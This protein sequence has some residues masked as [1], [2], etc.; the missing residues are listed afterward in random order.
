MIL[1]VAVQTEVNKTLIH[2]IAGV[3]ATWEATFMPTIDDLRKAGNKAKESKAVTLY[4]AVDP[5][6]EAEV[7]FGL[8]EKVSGPAG[9][10][11]SVT[12]QV[13]LTFR[14]AQ[15]EAQVERA[16]ALAHRE[17]VGALEKYIEPAQQLL[18]SHLEGR[19]G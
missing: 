15:T 8:E 6:G 1:Q 7:S 19:S 12:V 4:S 2:T 16:L 9:T 14:C 3:P 18:V 5:K 11:S 10:Y 13:R 17:C